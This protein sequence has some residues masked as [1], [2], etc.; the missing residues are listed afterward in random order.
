MDPSLSVVMEVVEPG[1]PDTETSQTNLNSD[2]TLFIVLKQILS[3]WSWPRLEELEGRLI[4]S[5]L[6]QNQSTLE[7][8]ISR[9]FSQQCPGIITFEFYGNMRFM[10]TAEIRSEFPRK[11]EK[12]EDY[13][14]KISIP[15]KRKMDLWHAEH[16]DK[17]ERKLE[18]MNQQ[19]SFLPRYFW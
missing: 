17:R 4:Q 9:I 5:I 1:E 12:N 6:L 10:N 15:T 13:G 18:R 2:S 19:D 14:N 16:T 7:D 8:P 3:S 11:S